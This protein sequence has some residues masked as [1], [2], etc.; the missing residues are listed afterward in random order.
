[1]ERFMDVQTYLRKLNVKVPFYFLMFC[2]ISLFWVEWCSEVCSD[3]P[4]PFVCFTR[5]SYNLMSWIWILQNKF[6]F[7]KFPQARREAHLWGRVCPGTITIKA[8]VCFVWCYI[9]LFILANISHSKYAFGIYKRIQ[10]SVPRHS[11]KLPMQMFV[12]F[13]W[14]LSKSWSWCIEYLH[15][16]KNIYRVSQK[17]VW[18]KKTWPLLLW[19][20]SEREKLVC[21]GKFISNAAG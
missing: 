17:K 12:N 9:N 2:H 5:F 20:P 13:R 6:C 4:L 1:M 21:I 7:V 18:S 3:V 11:F 16:Y 10:K 8:C 19:Y 14:H 15:I